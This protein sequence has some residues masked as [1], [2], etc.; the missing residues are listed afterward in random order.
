MNQG[1]LLPSCQRLPQ[2]PARRLTLPDGSQVR[3]N[4]DSRLTCPANFTDSNRDVALA[5]EAFFEVTHDPAHPFRVR[6]GGAL[7]RVLGTSFNVRA[8][9]DSVRVLVHTGRV[10]LSGVRQTVVL[11][12]NQQATYLA[13]SD[14]IRRAGLPDANQLTY[15]TGRLS[16]TNTSLA[17]VVQ[18]LRNAY[19]TDI[20][21]S[22]SALGRCRLTVDFGSEPVDAVLVAETLSLTV[23]REGNARVLTGTGC[24][25]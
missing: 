20:R 12:P 1:K 10:Q 13:L 18:T 19:G 25:L 6:A 24:G 21:L 5:G 4:R 22:D 2:L 14:T 15:Q 9:G 8:V 7:I 16:F 3:L 17:E 11:T 23:R